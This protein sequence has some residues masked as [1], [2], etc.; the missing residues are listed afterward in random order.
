MNS[1]QSIPQSTAEKAVSAIGLGYDLS[2]DIRLSYCKPGPGGSRLIELDQTLTRELRLPNSVVVP[3]V[4]ISIKCGKGE[5]NRLS[6]DFVCFSQMSERFNRELAL[7][8]KIPSVLFNVMFDFQ[9]C[10]PIDATSTKALAFD[11]CFIS[12]YNIELEARTKIMLCEHVIREVPSTWDPDAL[13]GFIQKYGTHVILGV[14]MGGK[15]VIHVKQLE[16]SNLYLSEMQ[17]LLQTLADERYSEDPNG[18][19]NTNRLPKKLKD[20][21]FKVWEYN[22]QPAGFTHSD[23]RFS[24]QE[25]IATICVRRGGREDCQAHKQ[26]LATIPDSPDVISMSLVPIASLLN[27]VPGS[28]YLVYAM[29]L[30]LRSKPRVEDLRQFLHFQLPRQWAPIY[31]DLPLGRQRWRHS[32]PSLRFTFLGPKLY[33]N[34]S[35]IT[36]EDRPVTGMHLY[37]E[38]KKCNQ[39]SLHLQHLSR[40]PPILQLS[41]NNHCMVNEDNPSHRGYYEPVKRSLLSHVCTAPV[42]CNEECTVGD[43]APIVTKAWLDV[44]DMGNVK[45]VLFLRLGFSLVAS[46]RI[47]RTEWDGGAGLSRKSVPFSMLLSA[48]FSTALTQ[49]KK[50]SKT[51]TNTPRPGELNGQAKLSKLAKFVDTQQIVRGPENLP[52]CW[53]VTGGRLCVDGTK[54]SLRVK[55]SL[56]S[57]ATGDDLVS[58]L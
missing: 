57:R 13:A 18:T 40:L 34:T 29:N 32:Y 37:L 10:W 23:I 8:G 15:D 20:E 6:S 39:L 9:G 27:G 47:R 5:R 41:E 53:V 50:Q 26:W 54:I 33:V 56:L 25:D 52:G 43:F 17:Q 4:P 58:S 51:N 28:G 36:S 46:A 14:K 3:N 45:K 21:R 2:N 38:G 1:S 31:G 12:L 19:I 42:E 24:E 44:R 55:Y 11:G 22:A 49:P 30:Y 16:N 7:S 35:Q 48:M